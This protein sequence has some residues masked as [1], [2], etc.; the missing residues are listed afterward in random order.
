MKLPEVQA[1][2]LN[3]PEFQVTLNEGH[4][5]KKGIKTSKI[6]LYILIQFVY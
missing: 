4:F 3:R 2:F 1:L 6:C 5:P